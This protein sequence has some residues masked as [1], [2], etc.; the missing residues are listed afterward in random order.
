MASN[1]KELVLFVFRCHL[2]FI[3]DSPLV[4]LLLLGISHFNVQ[5]LASFGRQRMQIV[6]AYNTHDG[7][8]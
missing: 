2:E 4:L 3:V 6:V 8:Y 7:C 5:A 1:G